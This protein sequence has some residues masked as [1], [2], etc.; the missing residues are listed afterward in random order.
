MTD[1][2]LATQGIL[3]LLTSITTLFLSWRWLYGDNTI[4]PP[5]PQFLTSITTFQLISYIS[6]TI[7]ISF[8]F[9]MI[10]QSVRPYQ[11]ADYPILTWK[12]LFINGFSVEGDRDVKLIFIGVMCG[13]FFVIG[14][15]Q[16]IYGNAQSNP[17]WRTLGMLQLI[18]VVVMVIISCIIL[19]QYQVA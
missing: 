13:L 6:I 19:I 18:F 5:P 12:Q 14:G 4:Y 11:P 17:L 8:L 10:I 9:Y 16:F 3:S 15:I 2:F 1:S 7:F